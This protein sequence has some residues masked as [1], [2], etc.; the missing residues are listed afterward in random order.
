MIFTP[1]YSFSSI[2]DASRQ[3]RRHYPD[4]CC[5]HREFFYLWWLY[6]KRW[7]D[8]THYP[9]D[10]W[11][12][13]VYICDSGSPIR[14]E[15]ILEEIGVSYQTLAPASYDLDPSKEVYLKRYPTEL[16]HFSGSARAHIDYLKC[17]RAVNTDYLL[18]ETDLLIAYDLPSDY[19]NTDF[20]TQQISYGRETIYEGAICWIDKDVVRTAFDAGHMDAFITGDINDKRFHEGQMFTRFC[21]GRK[22]EMDAN[23]TEDGEGRNPERPY[24]HK[25]TPGP[26]KK[27]LIENPIQHPWISRYL[28]Y[29]GPG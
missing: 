17:C 18:L 3:D 12:N 5:K 29:L 19:A 16:D 26:L 15:P 28:T 2:E 20:Y 9:R 4:L 6:T 27:F 10:Q 8:Q 23:A 21:K 25:T 22:K 7:C 14:L 11:D 13:K 1:W 24:V